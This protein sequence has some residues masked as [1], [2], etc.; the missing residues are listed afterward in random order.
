MKGWP[1]LTRVPMVILTTSPTAHERE[2]VLDLHCALLMKPDDYSGLG[3]VIA[4][5]FPY[6][7][8][9]D[10]ELPVAG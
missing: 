5:F 9:A 3:A 6:L 1:E 2:R 4:Q 7:F 10:A 8:A